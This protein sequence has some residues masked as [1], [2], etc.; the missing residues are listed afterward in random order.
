MKRTLAALTA[1]LV[2][3]GCAPNPAQN[4]PPAQVNTPAPVATETAPAATETTAAAG[5]ET[6]A[7]D[8]VV[9][10]ITPE[11]SKVEWVGSKVTRSHEGGFKKFAGEIGVV[12]GDAEKSNVV[13]EIENESLFA[14][15]EKLAGH[16][17][18]EDFFDIAK[19]PKSSF[20]STKV[21]KMGEGYEMTG[22]LTMH[23]VTK[24]LTFPANI[25]VAPEAVTAKAEFAINRMDFGIKYPG[26]ADDLIRSEVV[27]KLD[28]NAP[29]SK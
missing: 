22:D 6:P 24:S 13:V 29:V 8:L 19:F 10:K 12:N 7:G 1:C 17:K 16:L 23:G 25:T 27:I 4:V 2:L 11:T 28:L 15:D 26:K 5:T 21:A 18:G 3:A 14:D 20:K 9:Y